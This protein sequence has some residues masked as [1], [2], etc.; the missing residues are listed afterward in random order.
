MKEKYIGVSTN[1]ATKIT[2]IPTGG[3]YLSLK[4]ERGLRPPDISNED[5]LRIAMSKLEE[6]IERGLRYL[7]LSD[8]VDVEVVKPPFMIDSTDLTKDNMFELLSLVKSEL[9]NKDAVIVLHGTDTLAFEA[10]FLSFFLDHEIHKSKRVIIT[11]AIAPLLD[12]SEGVYAENNLLSSILVAQG[13]LKGVYVV[14][15]DKV[16][17]GTRAVKYKA[18][19][20]D[21][22]GEM[23]NHHDAFISSNVEEI[24]RV[25]LEMKIVVVNM[26][27]W[28]A[29]NNCLASTEGYTM[30]LEDRIARVTIFPG[31][32]EEVL[33]SLISS[34]I[35]EFNVRG[36]IIDSYGTGGIPKHLVKALEMITRS[37]I[38][39]LVT[40][41][42]LDPVVLLEKYV[43]GMRLKEIGG[44]IYSSLD[45]TRETAT[46]KFMWALAQRDEN[47]RR[48]IMT[49]AFRFES[50]LA[51]KH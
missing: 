1:I 50:V 44:E 17:L 32:R 45:M 46:I 9:S 24:A 41:Q 23:R 37:G 51:C 15:H 47:K 16:I 35:E 42:V 33:K 19:D 36:I 27:I 12:P 3:T 7:E 29:Y 25:N 31:M 21:L 10:S 28:N 48:E 5:E 11:G 2:V 8:K 43:V 20:V 6:V 49:K 13:A 26:G 40:T 39:V 14:F 4:T 22:N 30:E 34:K 38:P 18:L